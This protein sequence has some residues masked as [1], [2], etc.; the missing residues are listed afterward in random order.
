NSTTRSHSE[1]YLQFPRLESLDGILPAT[2]QISAG[3]YKK[4]RISEIFMESPGQ[5]FS[6]S[7]CRKRRNNGY[8][9]RRG[10]S[11]KRWDV[12]CR[13]GRNKTNHKR[14]RCR[15]RRGKGC[16]GT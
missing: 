13:A 15:N 11:S 4:K 6:L 9:I 2:Q 8:Y 7:P 14:R 5:D 10:C 12:K 3:K 1:P 16:R